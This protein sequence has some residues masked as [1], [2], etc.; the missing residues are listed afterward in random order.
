M[1]LSLVFGLLS[2]VIL[3]GY[4]LAQI[5]FSYLKFASNARKLRY[6]QYKVAEYDSKLNSKARKA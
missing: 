6:F 1:G 2:I 3:L 5:P 4:G